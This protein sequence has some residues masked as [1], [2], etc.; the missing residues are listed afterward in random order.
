[1]K[2]T[3]I[4]EVGADSICCEFTGTISSL[5]AISICRSVGVILDHVSAPVPDLTPLCTSLDRGV[6]GGIDPTSP[7][8]FRLDV[9]GPGQRSAVIAAVRDRTGWHNDPSDWHIN[10]TCRGGWWIAEVGCLHYS[11]RFH[12]LRR[13]PWSTNPVLAAIL[14]RTA[15]IAAGQIVHDPFC[16]TGTLL[17]AAHQ[18]GSSLRLTGTDHDRQTLGL[19]GANLHDHLIPATLISADAI[20][21]P[22]PEGAIDRVLSNL[23]FG[24]QVGSHAANA[25]LYPALVHEIARTLH[26]SGRAVLL[27]EDKRL[28]V[29][30]VAKVPGVKI[31]RQRLL[32]YGGAT[33]TAYTITPTRRIQRSRHGGAT[34]KLG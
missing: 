23:P 12:R 6:L 13:Q 16:G 7:I 30:A 2:P 27:T 25:T 24:K 34:C 18:A 21:F 31:I 29:D 33:P 20:P 17:I 4:T 32:R 22:H 28:L 15:K 26:P 8:R 19:A 10:I 11:R 1:M 9:L 5:H 14:A 3:S